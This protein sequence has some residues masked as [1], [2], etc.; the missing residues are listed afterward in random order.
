MRILILP[1]TREVLFEKAGTDLSC[2]SILFHM[3]NGCE[4]INSEEYKIIYPKSVYQLNSKTL[5]GMLFC[6]REERERDAGERNERTELI[7][8]YNPDGNIR[9]TYNKE[10]KEIVFYMNNLIKIHSEFDDTG[11]ENMVSFFN[12]YSESFRFKE[13]INITQDFTHLWPQ[14][15]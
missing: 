12:K 10:I 4:T 14:V 9:N 15:W 11:E 3:F 6:V 5:K 13:G 1:E 2:F 8:F 7:G